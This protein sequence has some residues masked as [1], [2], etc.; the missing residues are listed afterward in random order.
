MKEIYIRK[1]KDRINW[2]KLSRYQYLSASEYKVYWIREC[3][4]NAEVLSNLHASVSIL[5]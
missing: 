5:Y 3:G 4:S 2:V 1:N